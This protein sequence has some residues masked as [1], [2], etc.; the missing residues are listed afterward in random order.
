[1]IM[2]LTI[3]RGTFFTYRHQENIL[4]KPIVVLRGF[5]HHPNVALPNNA[6]FDIDTIQRLYG[7][8]NVRIL[9]QSIDDCNWK[10][11]NVEWDP[12]TTLE[13]YINYYRCLQHFLEVSKCAMHDTW[14]S[15]LDGA[16]SMLSIS[17]GDLIKYCY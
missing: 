17:E 3:I 8:Q 7:Q 4:N 10:S 9:R 13:S 15:K 2:K 6:Q 5:M 11:D 14:K 16:L 12:P 1:M